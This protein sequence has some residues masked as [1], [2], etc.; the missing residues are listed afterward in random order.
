ML[1]RSSSQP[2]CRI[3]VTRLPIAPHVLLVIDGQPNPRRRRRDDV[4]QVASAL[5]VPANPDRYCRDSCDLRD[6][7]AS[8]A[9]PRELVRR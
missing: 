5:A 9:T 7:H 2:D 3:T 6:P 4:R 1:E 8:V